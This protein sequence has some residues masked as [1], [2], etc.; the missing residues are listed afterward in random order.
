MS[1]ERAI[2][3]MLAVVLRG[4]EPDG[5]TVDALRD[6]VRDAV[7]AGRQEAQ[8]LRRV[9]SPSLARL[10]DLAVTL[11]ALNDGRAPE[12]S[13]P[14]VALASKARGQIDDHIARQQ[15]VL[16]TFN[17]ALFGRTGAGKS[18]LLSALAELDGSRVSRGESDWTVAV[19][20][21]SWEGC[22][23]YDTPG[24][25]GWG[26]TRSRSDLEETA[27]RAVEVADV[28]L[29]CFDSQSQQASEFSKVADWVREF[30][31]PTIAVLNCRNPMWRHP[32]RVPAAARANLSKAVRQHA[33]NIADS[34]TA[35]GMALRARMS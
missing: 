29:L 6:A 3:S 20:P 9:V 18:S 13:A 21:V 28:V 31:K 7:D 11:A 8:R 10:D 12:A 25:N 34:L 17:I 2:R 33:G 22:L 27:R 4:S 5:I 15:S 19:E 35:L 30:G 1:D 23:L 16:G 24:I 32:A 26:R 14:F